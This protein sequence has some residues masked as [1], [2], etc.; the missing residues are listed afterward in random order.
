VWPK[1]EKGNNLSG[2]MLFERNALRLY[3]DVF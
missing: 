3:F 2:L 1:E